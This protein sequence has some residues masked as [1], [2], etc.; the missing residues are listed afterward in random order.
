MEQV[1]V[2]KQVISYGKFKSGGWTGLKQ[3][4]ANTPTANQRASHIRKLIKALDQGE[5]FIKRDYEETVLKKVAKL[6]EDGT[7]WHPPG[8]P[9]G[10]EILAE[11]QEKMPAIHEEFGRKELTIELQWR[12]LTPDTLSD[13]KM[14]AAEMELLGDFFTEDAG[15]GVPHLQMTK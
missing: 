5:E 6:N 2:I 4:L 10:Y 15:P 8:E 11:N 1:P 12:A 7:L 9:M 13:F 14:T 3:K